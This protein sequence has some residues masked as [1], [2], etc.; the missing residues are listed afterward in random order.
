MNG[1]T[2]PCVTGHGGDG[3]LKFQDAEEV[4]NVELADAFQQMWTK[5]RC[6]DYRRRSSPVVSVQIYACYASLGQNRIHATFTGRKRRRNNIMVRFGG[7]VSSYP[8]RS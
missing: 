1:Y 7:C 2:P 6:V 5:R 8:H 4:S 3:F